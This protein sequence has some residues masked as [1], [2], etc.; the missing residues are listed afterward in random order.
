M[1]AKHSQER[2][3]ANTRARSNRRANTLESE[4]G[5]SA[6]S[7]AEMTNLLKKLNNSVSSKCCY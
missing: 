5:L 4:S 3:Q 7:G 6:D 2:R 1:A